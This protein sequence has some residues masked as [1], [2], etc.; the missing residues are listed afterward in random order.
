MRHVTI[1][2]QSSLVTAAQLAAIVAALQEQVTRDFYPRWGITATLTPLT[3]PASAKTVP[4]ASETIFVLD[5]SDQAD[6]LGYHELLQ[7][8][9]PIGF[10]FAADA[11]ADGATISSVLSHELLEQLVDPLAQCGVI[12]QLGPAF[13]ADANAWGLVAQ[14]TADPVENDSYEIGSVAV[15]N[16]VLPAWFSGAGKVFDFLRRLRA[17]LS[18]DAGGYISYST[19]LSNWKQVNAERAKHKYSRQQRRYT[20]RA[21]RMTQP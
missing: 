16:F 3:T 7:S 12:T 19:D 1:H 18:L 2:N 17:P 9:V 8:G 20:S 14:E 15:S 4:P 11:K 5:H 21:R 6:A 10:A 13:G